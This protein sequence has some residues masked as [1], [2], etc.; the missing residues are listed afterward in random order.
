MVMTTGEWGGTVHQTGPRKLA[1]LRSLARCPPM[2]DRDAHPLLRPTVFVPGRRGEV[3]TP[4][5]VVRK[6]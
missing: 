2:P 4:D 1:A 6:V 3:T 5:V